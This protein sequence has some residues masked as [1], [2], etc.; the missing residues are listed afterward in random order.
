MN[1]RFIRTALLV[2][3]LCVA[4]YV[5]TRGMIDAPVPFVP[6]TTLQS[7]DTSP[8]EPPVISVKGIWRGQGLM[9]CRKGTVARNSEGDYGSITIGISTTDASTLIGQ[10]QGYRYHFVD[11]TLPMKLAL[12]EHLWCAQGWEKNVWLSIGWSDGETWRQDPFS[13]RMYVTAIDRAGN[14]SKPSNI[15]VV[16]DDGISDARF[17]QA[18]GGTGPCAVSID[19][20]VGSWS[21]KD[22]DGAEA[23]LSMAGR[24]FYITSGTA[25]DSG[26]FD[27]RRGSS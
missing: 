4:Y 26:T 25:L 7:S 12:D 11:G 19:A 18:R 20:L 10:D 3:A 6:D 2:A 1:R 13:F 21:G 17:E 27:C 14:E 5:P 22:E 23:Q 15:I 9:Y 16:A 24:Q 8:P